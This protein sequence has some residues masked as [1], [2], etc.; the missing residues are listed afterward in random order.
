MVTASADAAE[1]SDAASC[2][3]AQDRLG[4]E[5]RVS[6]YPQFARV[7]RLWLQG[8][9]RPRHLRMCTR[10]HQVS[11][12]IMA[13]LSSLLI[14]NKKC[15]YNFLTKIAEI[16]MTNLKCFKPVTV[17]YYFFFLALEC[18]IMFILCIKQSC[19]TV[20][21]QLGSLENSLEKL[22]NYI[23]KKVLRPYRFLGRRVC[24]CKLL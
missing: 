13:D 22:G 24:S 21:W 20:N 8:L 6:R 15:T 23:L 5:G 16:H 1:T 18:V 11:G 7:L 17:S 12:N 10:R 3:S 9:L 4:G 19:R 2:R 14:N